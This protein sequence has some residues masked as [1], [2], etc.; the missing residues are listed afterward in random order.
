MIEIHVVVGVFVPGQF[1]HEF[2]VIELNGKLRSRRI[3]ALQLR[4][5]LFED[6]GYIF[7]PLLFG[8]FFLQVF[9]FLLMWRATQFFL[10][11]FQLHVQKIVALLLVDVGLHFFVN[12]LFDLKHLQLIGQ[13]TQQ[14][15]AKLLQIGHF[16]QFLLLGMLHFQVGCNHVHQ[17]PRAFDVFDGN[18]RFCRDFGAFLQNLHGRFFH[19]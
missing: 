14:I 9:D 12:L 1:N 8:C 13:M 7:R 19:G 10:N 5:F 2:K 4:H 16:E 15:I 3:H 17:Q 6:F 18:A 11:G